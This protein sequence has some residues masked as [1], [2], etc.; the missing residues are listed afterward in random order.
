MWYCTP[1]ATSYFMKFYFVKWNTFEKY[2]LKKSP[3]V[4]VKS[5]SKVMRVFEFYWW[6]HLWQ[7]FR[8]VANFLQNFS[9][10]RNTSFP[11]SGQVFN[12][13]YKNWYKWRVLVSKQ[14]YKILVKCWVKGVKN[15]TLMTSFSKVLQN[16]FKVIYR[17]QT[18]PETYGLP[19]ICIFKRSNLI[20]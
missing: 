8:T 7:T 17:D 6:R 4:K 16:S 3:Q 2:D 18:K 10:S 5:R 11:I 19:A 12:Q 20:L 13:N 1:A 14:N 15:G 9:I